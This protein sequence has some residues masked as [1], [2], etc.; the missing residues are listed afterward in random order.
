M[1]EPPS[2]LE[3]I[4]QH[5]K[6][7]TSS[8]QKIAEFILRDPSRLAFM[9][10]R[11]LADAVN[12][13]ES[14]VIRFA[15]TAGFEG[16][17]ALQSSAKR[18]VNT[19]LALHE[20]YLNKPHYTGTIL[21]TV[22]DSSIKNLQ[23]LSS[24]ADSDIECAAERIAQSRRCY[25]VGFRAAAGL[26]LIAASAINMLHHNCFQLSF[27]NGETID[28]MIGAD[29]QDVVLAITFRRYARRTL[30]I[31]NYLHKRGTFVIG[32][33]DSL[34]SPLKDSADILL[35]GDVESPTFAYSL[36][37]PHCIIDALV[38]ALSQKMEP[39]AAKLIKEWEDTFRPFDLL[40]GM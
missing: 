12:V 16:Y 19:R 23:A 7:F 38:L 4:G 26:A 6:E 34:F 29:P 27:E 3:F 35:V 5:N 11:Q 31:A 2:L 14:S 18:L 32:V 13:S 33:T 39:T 30:Q 15:Y 40:E 1:T 37:A 21:Q 24:L 17:R 28:E 22:V 9:N 36:I 10:A 25:I 8:Q 20:R